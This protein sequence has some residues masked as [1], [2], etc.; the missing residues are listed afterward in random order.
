MVLPPLI[1]MM[2]P[3][4]NVREMSTIL[5]T[6]GIPKNYSLFTLKEAD[7]AAYN[8]AQLPLYNLRERSPISSIA[9]F[10]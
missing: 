8:I 3:T 9:Y 4:M 6:P 5:Y 7:L 10:S 1:F 2:D